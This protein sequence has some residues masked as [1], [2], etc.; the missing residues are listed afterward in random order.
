MY[1]KDELLK[2][3]KENQVRF[4]RLQFTDIFGVMKNV[5]ITTSQLEKA[6]D[7]ELMFDGSSI[8]GFARIEE[9]D[10]YLIPDYGTW[11]VLPHNPETARLICDVYNLDKTPFHGDPRYI[12]R[13]A[14]AEAARLGFTMN[15][16]PEME[17]FLFQV[18][19]D[20][21]P[22]LKTHDLASYFDLAPVDLGEAARREMVLDLE[23]MGF[24]VEA[25]HHE[26]APGQHEIDFKYADALLAADHVQTCKFV[27]R[28]AAQRHH[29]HATFMP[30]PVFGIAGSGMHMNQSLFKAGVN[31]FYD[32]RGEREL[33]AT[34]Y[35][36]MGG[37]LKHA[38]ALTAILNPT[39]NSYKRLVSGYEAP[40]YV[41]WAEKNRSPLVRVPSKRGPSARVELRSPDPSCNPYLACAV[42]LMAGL[43][44]VK[45]KIAPPEPVECNIFCL[46]EQELQDKDLALLPGSLKEALDE[47]MRDTIILNTLGEHVAQRF[48]EA[49]LLE[50]N[51]Y[52][53]DV[54]LWEVERY[55]SK[56]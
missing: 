33:S 3:A 19:A 49:K 20:G 16:G 22:T 35:Y 6:L 38:P 12:L 39:V 31:A 50:W 54:S 34:A 40:V 46:S 13:R 4:I 8:D 36:Y 10:M 23:S 52:C 48:Y 51:E 45:N 28:Q 9:S 2:L 53:H 43:D 17:F 11:T 1:G 55:L 18:D 47:L 7:G 25:S 41:A 37:L 42:M 21:K 27:V 24:E 5:A 56:F 14:L 30:K 26:C 32:S 29:L 15:V 44:G